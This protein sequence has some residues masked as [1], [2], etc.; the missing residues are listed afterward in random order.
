VSQYGGVLG[1]VN[2]LLF[3]ASPDVGSIMDQQ[4]QTN[5]PDQN[6][7]FANSKWTRGP[8][9]EWIQNTGFNGPLAGA[10]DSLMTQWGQNAAAGYGNGDTARNQAIDASWGQFQRMNEPLMAQ[11][12]NKSRSDLL[13]MGLDMGSA[14]FNTGFG[15]TLD[16]NNR[17]R[18]NAQ[19]QAIAAGDRAQAQTFNQNRQSWLDP[20]GALGQ[21][22]G[23]LTMPGFKADE[24]ERAKMEMASYGQEMKNI[25]GLLQGGREVAGSLGIM[26]PVAK[27]E[28]TYNGPGSPNY[29]YG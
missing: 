28:P 15:N 13:N 14:G 26:P 22:Q 25:T 1:G 7:P 3:G 29:K 21:M 12:E 9:G 4:V 2:S 18:L 23:L 19:D 17:Q 27:S 10:A 5:R 20:L 6:T 8:N 24:S 16:A 11:Q